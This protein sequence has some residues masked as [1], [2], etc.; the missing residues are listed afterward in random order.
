MAITT[1]ADMA[2]NKYT[3]QWMHDPS[4]ATFFFNIQDSRSI[5]R[6]QSTHVTSS[7]NSFRPSTLQ[8]PIDIT[9]LLAAQIA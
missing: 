5:A 6:V 3:C 9:P 7:N 2:F 4:F 8:S 1:L